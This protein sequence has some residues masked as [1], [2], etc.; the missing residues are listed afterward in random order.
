MFLFV[1]YNKERLKA[2]SLSIQ[3]TKQQPTSKDFLHVPMLTYFSDESLRNGNN[4]YY[5]YYKPSK[6]VCH[7]QD[8]TTDKGDWDEKA[9]WRYHDRHKPTFETVTQ[10]IKKEKCIIIS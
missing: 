9:I 4:I 6:L 1:E 3:P 8:V 5:K 2:T 7:Q 10:N